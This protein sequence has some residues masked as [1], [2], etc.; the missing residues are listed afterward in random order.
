M[1]VE[2]TKYLNFPEYHNL[3]AQYT[4]LTL[5]H[6]ECE[7]VCPAAS[8]IVDRIAQYFSYFYKFLPF[9]DA[10]QRVV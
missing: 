7:R 3:T 2:I 6:K 4:L 5:G 9:V 1:L 8:V 10:C